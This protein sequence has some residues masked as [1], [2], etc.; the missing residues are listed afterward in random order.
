MKYLYVI[1]W[2]LPLSLQ[3]AAMEVARNSDQIQ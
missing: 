2:I 1:L 3:V